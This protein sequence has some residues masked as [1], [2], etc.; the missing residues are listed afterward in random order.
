LPIKGKEACMPLS[1]WVARQPIPSWVALP[2]KGQVE[3]QDHY[4]A[5]WQCKGQYAAGWQDSHY[6]AGW[7][8]LAKAKGA[9]VPVPSWV[10]SSP[11]PSWVAIAHCEQ[12]DL[13]IHLF[14]SVLVVIVLFLLGEIAGRGDEVQAALFIQPSGA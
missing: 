10:A 11:L 1:S 3:W 2:I 13:C 8:C 9:N 7:H 4:P 6:P 14:P 12:V 5:G